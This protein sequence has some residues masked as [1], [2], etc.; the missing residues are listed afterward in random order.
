METEA[1]LQTELTLQLLTPVTFAK[2]EYTEL[3]LTEPSGGDLI[4]AGKAITQMEQLVTLIYLNAK[5]PRGAVE[6]MKQRD[7][8][9]A[10]SFFGHFGDESPPTSGTSSPS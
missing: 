3:H 7:L 10:S 4:A 2:V 9:A 1:E 6:L 5:V 8:M